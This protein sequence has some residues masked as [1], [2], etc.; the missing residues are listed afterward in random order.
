MA[1]VTIHDI[2]PELLERLEARAKAFGRS[3][4]DEML[5]MIRR[6]LPKHRDRETMRRGARESH[7]RFR[8]RTFS[9]STDD[10]REDRER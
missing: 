2:E 1:D 8:G 5:I 3:V 4:E 6:S 10:I 7:E 9:D